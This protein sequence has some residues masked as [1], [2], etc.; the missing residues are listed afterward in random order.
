MWK[1]FLSFLFPRYCVY[2]K[3]LGNYICDQCFSYIRLDPTPICPVCARHSIDGS[4]HPRCVTSYSIDG[5]VSAV[6]YNRVIKKLLYQYKYTPYISDLRDEIG[7]LM[8]ESLEQSELFHFI[9]Q[10]SPIVIPVP[11][12]RR[13]LKRRGYNH[14]SLLCSYVA[15]YFHLEMIDD[16]VIRTRDTKPQFKLSKS[17]RSSNVQDAFELHNL[18]RGKI[19]GKT[20]VVVD[21]IATTRS[22]LREISKVLKRNGAKSVWGLV[23]ARE[24]L[25]RDNRT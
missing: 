15:Q 22:T 19:R 1:T 8:S 5:L 17:E 23:F 21:D 25:V 24:E 10:Q 12:H 14:A 11:L 4:T 7:Q 20:I 16:L 6:V 13:R 18:Y 3:R 9:R 2:C